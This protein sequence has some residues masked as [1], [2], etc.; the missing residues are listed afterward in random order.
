M[1]NTTSTTTLTIGRL[2]RA[3]GVNVETIRYYQR[4]GLINE[5]KKPIRGFRTYP[6][7]AVRQIQFIKRAQ[8]LGFSLSDIA[9]LL[10]LGAGKC[11]DVMHKAEEKRTRVEEQL[12]DLQALHRT[13]SD[14]IEA[15]RKGDHQQQ[16]PIVETLSSDSQ[17]H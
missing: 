3:A 15:C 1:N 4:I 12:N 17:E 9:D 7:D 10:E 2:A 6:P 13:L 16:C 14:L 5:P 8:Q 11:K